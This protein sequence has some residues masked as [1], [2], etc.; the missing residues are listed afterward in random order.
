MIL[1]TEAAQLGAAMDEGR[2]GCPE[3]FCKSRGRSHDDW[4]SAS[5]AAE[6]RYVGPTRSRELELF[7]VLLTAPAAFVA[8]AFHCW[9][10][11]R[12]IEARA[13]VRK[14][15]VAA[16]R[17]VL[18]SIV[19]EWASVLA[20]GAESALRPFGIS[21]Y[22]IHLALFFLGTPAFANLLVLDK[23]GIHF[24]KSYL[25]ATLCAAFAVVLVLAQYAISDVLHGID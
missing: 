12:L 3:T 18:L 4:L 9:L 11:R 6:R 16:S 5:L 15:L 21:L 8:S 14:P 19:A 24:R 1:S 7:G 13:F 25:V 20:L 17:L 2:P 10:L 22:G 23:I